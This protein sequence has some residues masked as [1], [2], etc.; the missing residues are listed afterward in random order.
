MNPRSGSARKRWE[1]F[2]A[3]RRPASRIAFAPWRVRETCRRRRVR[4]VNAWR[5]FERTAS[6]SNRVRRMGRVLTA[7]VGVREV[8]GDVF[9]WI[10][11]K[12]EYIGFDE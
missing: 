4:A 3:G 1:D 6:V 5:R 8:S 12:L 9:E 11:E 10:D 2:R 7:S